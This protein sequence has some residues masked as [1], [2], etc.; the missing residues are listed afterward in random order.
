MAQ[1]M[2]ADQGYDADWFR[3]ALEEKKDQAL[4][5]GTEIPRNARQ[6]RQA[7]IKT[8][9]PHRD[10]VWKAQGLATDHHTL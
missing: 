6:I 3:D 9:Q 10:Y 1:W 2:L 4:H 7:E 5:P 8:P